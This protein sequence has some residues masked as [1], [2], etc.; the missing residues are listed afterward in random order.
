LIFGTGFGPTTPAM[1]PGQIIASPAP[2]SDPAQL[3]ITIGGITANVQFAGIV[4]SGEYQFN[5]IV[6]VVPDG[7]QPIVATIGGQSSQLSLSIP[8]RN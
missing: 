7:D 3:K 1:S 6:P 5:V 4:A 2:L 8:V